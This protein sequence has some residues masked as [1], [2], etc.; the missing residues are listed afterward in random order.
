LFHEFSASWERFYLTFVDHPTNKTGDDGARAYAELFCAL[1]ERPGGVPGSENDI[2][3]PGVRQ[4]LRES[5]FVGGVGKLDRVSFSALASRR[6]RASAIYDMYRKS[7]AKE[8]FWS[9]Q[10][11]AVETEPTATAVVEDLK[12]KGNGDAFLH[13]RNNLFRAWVGKFPDKAGALARELQLQQQG[14]ETYVVN[15]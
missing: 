2:Q 10:C 3:D 12:K 5:Q 7:H 11:I 15:E 8:S 9:V 6:N 4:A 1:A 14:F 13:F